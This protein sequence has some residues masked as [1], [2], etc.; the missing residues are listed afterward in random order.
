M[1]NTT[2][3]IILGCSAVAA[4]VAS[5]SAE[6]QTEINTGYHSIYEFRGVEVGDNLVTAGIDASTEIAPGLSLSAGVW[7]GDSNSNNGNSHFE[8]LDLYFSLTKSYERFDVS[9][10]YTHYGFIGGLSENN[11]SEWFIG[12]STDLGRG[13]GLSLNFYRDLDA[14]EGS[15]IEAEFTKSYTAFDNVAI[16]LAAGISY[17]DGYN[18][19]TNGGSLNGLNSYYISA[20]SPWEI[21]KG[22]VMTPY[23]KFVVADSELASGE[24]GE[25]NNLLLGGV[26]FSY[27]F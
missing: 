10:G 21:G 22:V 3:S 19:D 17:S 24:D 4:S 1:N 23:L 9:V 13:V 15:Y 2:K 18:S 16:D 7:Y 12:A 14:F 5:A 26:S 6:I 27:A 20:S 25:S 8:E 11:T